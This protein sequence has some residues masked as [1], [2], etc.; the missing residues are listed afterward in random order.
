[1]RRVPDQQLLSPLLLLLLLLLPHFP[2]EGLGHRGDRDPLF[3][4]FCRGFLGLQ[5]RK[6]RL[7]PR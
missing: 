2:I 3:P 7:G 5:E 1:M 6:V 4:P